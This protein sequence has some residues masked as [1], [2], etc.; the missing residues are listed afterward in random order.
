[1]VDILI[2]KNFYICV[3]INFDS[4]NCRTLRKTSHRLSV[5]PQSRLICLLCT[6]VLYMCCLQSLSSVWINTHPTYHV[7]SLW[8]LHVTEFDSSFKEHLCT[9]LGFLKQ[10]HIQS[11]Q[12]S[13]SMSCSLWVGQ[14]DQ[15]EIMDLTSLQDRCLYNQMLSFVAVGMVL[16]RSSPALKL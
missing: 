8:Q 15:F 5:C 16:R 6:Q 2:Q 10:D 3:K 4:L 14:E 11:A 1:M 13:Q 7:Q 12:N 9:H